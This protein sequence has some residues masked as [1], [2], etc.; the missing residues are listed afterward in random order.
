MP[1]LMGRNFVTLPPDFY[2][3]PILMLTYT[4]PE[5]RAAPPTREKPWILLLL[6]FAWLWPGVFSHDLWKPDEIWFNEAVNGVLS[7]GSW[8]QPQV[9]GRQDGGMPFVYV[10]LAAWCRR[11]LSPW[12]T[13]AYSAMRLASV[14]FTAVGLTA[15]GMAGFHLAGRHQGRSVVLILIGCAGLITGG[16]LLG[17]ASVQ[18][19][20]AG[21]CLYG[22]AVARR[23]AIF[24]AL[25]LGCGWALLS[26]S[27]GWAVMAALMLAACLL[28][29][30]PVWRS[31]RFAVALAAAFALAVP[32]A[33]VYPLAL[34][35]VSPEAFSGWLNHHVF[36]VFGGLAT[37]SA[38]FSLPY[39]L[40]NLLWFAFPAWPLALWTFSRRRF[41]S[42]SW[43]GPTVLWLAAVGLLLAAAPQ[44][45]ADNLILLLPPLAVLGACRLDSLRRGAAAFFNWFG[46]MIF[47]LLAVFLWIGFSAMNFGWPAKLAERSAYFSPYYTPEFDVMPML[48]A[49]LF[50]PLWLWAVTRKNVKGRQAVTNW[51]AGMT[52]V[53]A[54]LMTLFLPWLDAAKSYRPVV[55]RMEAA[56]P[57]ELRE[58]RACF[59]I[60]ETAV[61][62]RVSWR[63][64]GSLP[65]E[66]GKSACGYRLI[67]ANADAAVP[68]GWRE[69]W[70]GGR[71]RNKNERFLLLQRL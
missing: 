45:H 41:L 46:I 32:L 22:L 40:K 62:A 54:L 9:P 26:V 70:Q 37:F 2:R 33:A 67:Q 56:V 39:Y 16:H 19:A 38:A 36:G 20:A 35:Q 18:F 10:W 58:R 57:A 60:D 51:A 65:F 15:C 52:L 66:I 34:Y 17:G 23:R 69:V 3:K 27:A 24:A 6:A 68:A 64:Y 71:P 11:L 47:G 59:S 5:M 14:L 7:G 53:W 13:D 4:P 29:L 12:L 28:P 61:L 25:L 44:T 42:E 31:R 63:E 1:C 8:L 49:L 48:T 50:T 30:F 21:L 55:A 43:G